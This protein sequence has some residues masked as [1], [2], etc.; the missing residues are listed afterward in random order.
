VYTIGVGSIWERATGTRITAITTKSRP[1][2][3]FNMMMS[4]RTYWQAARRKTLEGRFSSLKSQTPRK[5]RR[6]GVH[7]TG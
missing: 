4:S 6:Y 3:R 2:I 5:G 1:A 7:S